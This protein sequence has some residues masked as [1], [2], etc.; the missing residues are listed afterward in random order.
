MHDNG[1]IRQNAVISLLESN[2]M[3]RGLLMINETD[4]VKEALRY[5]F[6][7][8]DSLDTNLIGKAFHPS[9]HLM[10]STSKGLVSASLNDWFGYINSIKTSY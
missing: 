6:D 3:G 1:R 10:E 2:N 5:F 8:F 7:G 4:K 9:S